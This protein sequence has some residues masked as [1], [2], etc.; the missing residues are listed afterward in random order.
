[1]NLTDT[2]S[3]LFLYLV[4]FRRQ[5]RK[6]MTPEMA[7]V[8]RQLLDIF[9]EQK[10]MVGGDANL[11]KLYER[12]KYV[13]VVL[14]DEI[15]INSN[16]AYSSAW[17]DEILEWEYFKT[18]IAGEEFF[19]LLESEGEKDE[20]LAEIYYTALSLGF[21]GQYA[22][23]PT[24]ILDLKRRLYRMLPGRFSDQDARITPDAYYVGEGAG[25]PYKSLINLGRIVLVCATILI[26]MLIIYPVIKRSITRDLRGYLVEMKSA[27]KPPDV[28]AEPISDAED[29]GDAEN[30]DADENDEDGEDSDDGSRWYKP[31]TWGGDDDEDEDDDSST[32]PP[33]GEDEGD[34][35]DGD[36]DGGD[37]E[38][39]KDEGDD[40]DDDTGAGA[41]ADEDEDA[42]DDED[43]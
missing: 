26:G 20:D 15:L 13:L 28:K 23:S 16:W 25:D 43:E 34:D 3:N 27:V 14:A 39:N 19:N 4:T 37:D 33:D 17:E 6:G 21:V 36:E 31:W 38:D 24:K 9:E 35:E 42:E 18:R 12:V 8:R 40:A 1:M 7:V 22:D 2:C 29:D 10:Q 11:E 5:V 41:D 30:A 32:E